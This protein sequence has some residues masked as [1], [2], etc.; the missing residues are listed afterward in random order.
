MG[1]PR[2]WTMKDDC[3]A[4]DRLYGMYLLL[5]PPGER[6]DAALARLYRMAAYTECPAWK[7]PRLRPA[8]NLCVSPESP[9]LSNDQPLHGEK[10]RKGP[11]SGST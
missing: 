3:E 2:L 7:P 10:C 4:L 8:L 11:P 5:Y 6:R 9:V 1:Q